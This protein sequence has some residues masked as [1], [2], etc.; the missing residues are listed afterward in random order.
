MRIIIFANGMM[1][2]PVVE[3]SRWVHPGDLIVAADGGTLHALDAGITPAHIVGDLDSLPADFQALLRLAGTEFHVY[4]PAKDENDLELALLWAAWSMTLGAE[5]MEIV[6][7]GITVLGALGGRPDQE[8][9]NMLLLSLPALRHL[10]VIIANGPWTIRLAL[11]EKPLSLQ[12]HPGDTL[13]L[14]PLAGPANGI[15]THG[16]SYALNDETLEF[17]TAHGV[18]NEFTA[19][20][21]S[22][23]LKEGMLWCFHES[24]T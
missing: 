10:D 12:G 8:L 9:A 5:D 20:E 2:H 21:V 4:P 3:A 17:G 24:K 11:P 7:E 14:L 1:P 18:S 13:S 15:T 23:E 16:L 22:V 6:P 19:A